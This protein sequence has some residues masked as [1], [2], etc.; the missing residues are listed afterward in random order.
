MTKPEILAPAGGSESIVSAVRCG[1]DAVYFGGKSF[2][3]RRNASNFG[4]DEIERAIQYCHA[5]AV[6][7]YITLN[8]LVSDRELDEA[9]DEIIRVCRLGADGFIVQDTGIAR[10]IKEICSGIPLHA[11]TQMSVSSAY[12]INLLEDAGFSRAVIPREC[13]REE[14]ESIASS[15]GIELE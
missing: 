3:A 2:N 4:Y 14:L 5:R 1:A 11:S 9:K 12:G 8:T 6:K 13:S 7:V 15:T 10:L